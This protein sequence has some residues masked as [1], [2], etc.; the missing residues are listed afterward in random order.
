MTP[1]INSTTTPEFNLHLCLVSSAPA[2]FSLLCG[3]LFSHF[4]LCDGAPPLFQSSE[5]LTSVLR[6]C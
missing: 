4:A 1:P 3:V 2:I 6:R 5:P